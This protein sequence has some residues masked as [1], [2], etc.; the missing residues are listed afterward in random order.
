ML[1][2]NRS[3]A[4][5]V[6]GTSAFKACDL[7]GVQPTGTFGPG[8]G[9]H[10]LAGIVQLHCNTLWDYQIEIGDIGQLEANDK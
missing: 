3:P 7:C 8:N 4:T 2:I 5:S 9:L 6:A 1:T 10:G